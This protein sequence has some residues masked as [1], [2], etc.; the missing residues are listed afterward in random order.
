MNMQEIESSL[1]GKEG[2]FGNIRDVLAPEGFSLANW[3]YHQGYLDRKLDDKGMVYLRLPIQVEEGNLDN[4]DALI[5]FG[6]PFVLK[7]V[8][9]TGTEENIGYSI[10]PN[11]AAL[12]NQFQE[13]VDKDAPVEEDW[14][15]VAAQVVRGVEKLFP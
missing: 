10:V 9:Q 2:F 3:D 4:T 13:P 12:V 14:V 15:E 6:T 5:Q 7:H 8:Y 1:K 11:V